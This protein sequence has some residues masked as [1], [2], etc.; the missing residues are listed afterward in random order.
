MTRNIENQVRRL[1]SQPDFNLSL[2]DGQTQASES[3]PPNILSAYMS[4]HFNLIQ[5]TL[6][7]C[8][9]PFA[10]NHPE[11]LVLGILDIWN[12]EE[13]GIGS[14]VSTED[15]NERCKKVIQLLLAL[16][17]PAQFVIS[18]VNIRVKEMRTRK[19]RK[20]VVM[21]R[22]Y[23]DMGHRQSKYCL[24]VYTYLVYCHQFIQVESK[25]ETQ[26]AAS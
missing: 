17:I 26:N 19:I 24:F 11:K 25:D 22:G 4:S 14:G 6:V 8:L 3:N 7:S 1:N 13:S 16:Q 10:R 20:E 21:N 15:F 9:T 2:L 18:A 5:Q 23:A 12:L